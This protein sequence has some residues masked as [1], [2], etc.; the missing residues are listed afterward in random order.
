[1]IMPYIEEQ[2]TSADMISEFR[3]YNHNPVI[4]DNE[5]FDMENMT[6]DATP[7]IET[8]PKRSKLTITDNGDPIDVLAVT[9]KDKIMV[10]YSKEG[11]NSMTV[12]TGAGANTSFDPDLWELIGTDY[13]LKLVVNNDYRTDWLKGQLKEAYNGDTNVS[14]YGSNGRKVHPITMND[15]VER[16]ITEDGFGVHEWLTHPF[17]LFDKIGDMDHI[18]TLDWL[19]P[20]GDGWG[21]Y[22]QNHGNSATACPSN[23]DY[24]GIYYAIKKEDENTMTGVPGTPAY[25]KADCRVYTDGAMYFRDENFKD[26]RVFFGDDSFSGGTLPKTYQVKMRGG[27]FAPASASSF[28]YAYKL[29]IY[30]PD[31][32]CPLRNWGYGKNVTDS[33]FNTAAYNATRKMYV[34][35]GSF[36]YPEECG[37]VL[38]V[39]VSDLV[40]TITVSAEAELLREIQP[41]DIV[42][43]GEEEIM[44]ASVNVD[45]HQITIRANHGEILPGD[46]VDYPKEGLWLAQLDL[47]TNKLKNQTIICDLQRKNEKHQ[48]VEM[49]ANIVLFPEKYVINT[50]NTEKIWNYI[51][52]TSLTEPGDWSDYSSFFK[53]VDGEYVQL[54][55]TTLYE[56]D[57][58]YYRDL[59]TEN[60]RDVS[61]LVP[62]SANSEGAIVS[63]VDRTGDIINDGTDVPIDDS[64]PANP[65]EGDWYIDNNSVPAV[66]KKFTG[67]IWA[68]Q[69]IFLKLESPE[70][71][72]FGEGNVVDIK[73]S[74]SDSITSYIYSPDDYEWKTFTIDSIS[75]SEADADKE[76]KE[77]LHIQIELDLTGYVGSS[78]I[79][80][81]VHIAPYKIKRPIPV[82]DYVIECQNRLWGCRYGENERGKFVNEIYA[83]KAGDATIWT[84]LKN[85]AADSYYVSLGD[86][87]EFTGAVN[88]NGTPVFF[89][90]DKIHRIMGYYPAQYQLTTI[91]GDG[92]DKGSDKSV[93]VLN[94][95]VYYNSPH[96]IMA[97]RGNAPQKISYALGNEKYSDVVGGYWKEKLYFSCIDK[98]SNAVL[99]A[100]NTESNLWCKENDDRATDMFNWEGKLFGLNEG[101]LLVF[102]G[103]GGNE[104]GELPFM[105]QSGNIGYLSPA[106]KRLNKITLRVKLPITSKATV[107]IQY[108]SDGIWRHITE[109]R[110]S[111]NVTSYAVPI[112]PFRCDHF[113]I[114]IKGNGE[115]TLMQLC[116]YWKEGSDNA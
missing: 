47:S 62:Y 11:S 97:W 79:V 73:F 88:Y 75:E 60:Y 89:R 29:V 83:S 31:H 104:E 24:I 8:R 105:I 51:L 111:R 63:I 94:G 34:C 19:Y 4:G 3:G 110:P 17:Y 90:K 33:T 56:P 26:A 86:D 15:N 78:F 98:N 35:Y 87:G 61:P 107:E 21:S 44:V 74:G 49:G 112:K 42:I 67:G 66:A 113:S 55:D 14:L 103:D 68:A 100:F 16:K 59:V 5:F 114:R 41:N 43:I 22:G 27:W 77:Y 64:A 84:Y 39:N 20:S 70:K 58:Y 46:T 54:T 109:I 82:M 76:T 10:A 6:S 102:E 115:F 95:V 9:G 36:N 1:M 108:D 71:K 91:D 65:D 53:L 106:R 25:I 80:K 45:T 72:M 2:Q 23:C 18:N 40:D 116:K 30:D 12:T 92:I 13:Y 37:T 48:I 81:G 96:G 85:T 57:T 28:Y 38:G 101:E 69:T 52:L 99:F 7:S 32:D 93:T 50:I